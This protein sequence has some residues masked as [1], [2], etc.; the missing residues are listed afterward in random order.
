MADKIDFASVSYVLG[1]LSIVLSFVSSWGLGG[2]IT[3]I[4]GLVHANKYNVPKAKKL[5][6]IG[7][8]IGSIF[9]IVSIIL[10]V[11]SINSSGSF[12]LI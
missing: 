3:G 4:V 12:P 6:I 8:I 10:T 7:I 9:F 2:L 1:I 5:N 11:Y